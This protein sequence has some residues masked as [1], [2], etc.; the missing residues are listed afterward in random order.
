MEEE[1]SSRMRQGRGIFPHYGKLRVTRDR[2]TRD[3]ITQI[4]A[5]L[6][7]FF[8]VHLWSKYT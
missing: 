6:E 3:R 2:I 8:L 4:I 7:Y 5:Q 1:E